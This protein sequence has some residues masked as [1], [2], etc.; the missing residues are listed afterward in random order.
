MTVWTLIRR[1]LLYYRRTHLGVL[2][3]A[4]V[5]TAVLVGALAV[6]DSVRGSLREMALARLGAVEVALTAEGRFFR[7]ALAGELAGELDA[8]VAPVLAMRGSA[9]LEDGPA[10]VNRV[11]VLGVDA[12]FWKLGGSGLGFG[13]G[14]ADEV[15]L[16][17]R[18]A[19]EL[20][21]G[22]GDSVRLRF[23][24]PSLLPRDA[25]LSSAKDA[26]VGI[27]LTVRAVASDKDFGRFGLRANQLPPANAFVPLG[28]LQRSIGLPERANVLLA[29][30]GPSPLTVPAADEALRRAWRLADAELEVRA[31]AGRGQLELRSRRI[32]LDP[33]V[34]AAVP[35]PATGVLAYF[36]NEIR[37]G[38]RTTPYSMVAA[39]G[40]MNG[41]GIAPPLPEGMAD[42]EI[43]IN[44]W[45]ADD[46]KAAVG[47]ELELTYFVVGPKRS[48]REESRRFRVAAIVPIEGAAAD[49]ELMPDFPGLSEAD[50]CRDWDPD[51]PLKLDRIRPKDEAYWD[52]HRGT[53]KAFLTL[54]A[55]RGIWANRFGDLTAVRF[56]GG[57]LAPA[58]LAE[59]IRRRLDPAEV[60]LFFRPVRRD[61]LAASSQGLD[62]GLLFM[63]LSMFL[64]VAAAVLMGLLFVFGMSQRA[65][66][67]G[68]LLAVGLSGRRVRRI[69]LAE[70][71]VLAVAGG[72]IGAAAGLA[73]TRGVLWALA[74]IWAGAVARTSGLGFHVRPI[75]VA[76]GSLGG[77]AVAAA[78]MRLAL[79]R[80]LARPARELLARGAALGPAGRAPRRRRGWGL[81][82]ALLA[83]AAGVA[84]VV[85]A[86]VG[87][88]RAAAGAFFASGALLLV[89]GLAMCHWL[90]GLLDRPGGSPAGSLARL[91]LRNAARRRGRSLATIVLLACGSFLVV[92]VGAN[93]QD[94]YRDAD[95]RDSG[96]GGFALVGDAATGVYH[97]LN[98][99]EGR[100]AVGLD[101]ADLAGVRFVQLR[102][103][104]G[105]E[106]SCLNL[107][108]AQ[109]PRLLGVD[110]EPLA[111]RGA[112]RFVKT[113]VP[114][115]RPWELLAGGEW[116]GAIPAIADEATVV[117]GLGRKLG[118]RITYT[119]E[120][121]RRFDVRFVAVMANSVLQ[122]NVLIA[123]RD[124]ERMFPSE[125]GYRS[126]LIDAPPDRAAAL[127]RTL[128]GA[129][130]DN[131]LELAQA[132]RRL[133]EFNEVQDTYLTIFQALGGLGLLLGS[134]GLAVV[135]G[136]NVMERRGE[137]ALLRAVGFSRGAVRG[138]VFIEHGLTLGL[139][140]G[141]GVIA[142]VVAVLGAL[143][144]P[145]AD[146]PYV[147]LAGTLLAVGI[148][149]V[150]WTCLA[151]MWAIRGPLLAALRSE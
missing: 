78:A 110:P 141:C 137:L 66:Q 35:T 71:A 19:D 94:P 43:V 87:R 144:S 59:Q 7:A 98:T 10:R 151:T 84:V 67:V 20:A 85:A 134:V 25:P 116:D 61:A 89:A 36:V 120:R 46:L 101:G 51:I 146:V 80:Q 63:G 102:V 113:L 149:G 90:L 128:A 1:S 127:A 48:L 103:R 9:T 145:G 3:G 79:G 15:I 147:W 132:P 125:A 30:A 34:A 133:A 75:T 77:I 70:G 81:M 38:R 28:L 106:A 40:P 11:E 83:T 39:V 91:G 126:F 139:G 150:L 143:G 97:D 29:G 121:G 68:T 99:P 129:L 5:A 119:D 57:T 42:D 138:M 55:G 114:T 41:D 50:N 37:L 52:D 109:Q 53:P 17:R 49:R 27:T 92:A 32:F 44:R 60:G 31:V 136:R 107:N 115:D 112:F 76:M 26:S 100:R 2:A 74:S 64:V 62:F 13:G 65:G 104:A 135:V 108:R 140:L 47:D 12:R 56:D 124:F 111:R 123:E 105:D 131:G 21:V 82:V 16:S 72:L 148:N 33:P 45:L 93:R 24:R 117:W 122:G 23:E 96:T 58:G 130:A 22:V 6:G 14:D 54:R 73:Y 118:D 69:L 88:G 8:E 95:R 86:G 4:A 142:A 18:L